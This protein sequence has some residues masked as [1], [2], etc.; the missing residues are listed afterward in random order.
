MSDPG[1]SQDRRVVL[2]DVGVD[3]LRAVT[4]YLDDLVRECQLIEVGAGQG[5]AT[6]EPVHHLA[7]GLLAVDRVHELQ[8]QVVEAVDRG[9]DHL[10]LVLAVTERAPE[11]MA[12]LGVLLDEAAELQR[13]GCLLL[14]P[15]PSELDRRLR[16]AL[17]QITAQ[18][19]DHAEPRPFESAPRPTT[20]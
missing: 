1:P 16:W 9:H 5:L 19:A 12:K 2:L 8:P 4:R 14:A 15:L 3:V 7:D 20:A 13:R 18:V 6:T 11:R 10:D 17:D